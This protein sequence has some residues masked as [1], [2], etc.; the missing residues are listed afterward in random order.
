MELRT[1]ESLL[2]LQCTE[3]NAEH[4]RWN[5]MARV[6][7]VRLAGF[8]SPADRFENSAFTKA[9]SQ[10]GTMNRR[11]DPIHLPRGT[12]VTLRTEKMEKK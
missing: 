9:P 1:G 3:R 6:V 10:L 4:S 2:D 5:L 12:R 7:E 11:G 8:G